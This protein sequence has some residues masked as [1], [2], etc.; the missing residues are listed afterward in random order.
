M[1]ICLSFCAFKSPLI[2]IMAVITVDV[3]NYHSLWNG[4]FTLAPA[5]IFRLG[6]IFIV[7]VIFFII[8]ITELLMLTGILPFLSCF[9]IR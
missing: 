8:I 6:E 7:I 2:I 5:C 3:C 4:M 1:I 9:I